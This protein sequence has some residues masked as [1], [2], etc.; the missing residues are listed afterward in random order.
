MYP[1]YLLHLELYRKMS[2]IP[3]QQQLDRYSPAMVLL[4]KGIYAGQVGYSNT[5][6]G[7][8][9]PWYGLSDVI[10]AL[11]FLYN[12]WFVFTHLRR[13]SWQWIR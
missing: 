4:I 6:T 9:H 13:A 5:C 2:A 8:L 11:L 10:V 3:V 7:I 12:A 1:V